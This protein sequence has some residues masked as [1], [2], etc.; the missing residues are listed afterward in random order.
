MS[1]NLERFGK[2]PIP[3]IGT[4]GVRRSPFEDVRERT[5]GTL[6]GVWAKLS[7]LAG[8]RG[9]DGRYH[10]WGLSRTHGDEPSQKALALAHSEVYLQ[11]LRTPIRALDQEWCSQERSGEFMYVENLQSFYPADTS[12]GSARHLSSL[13]L[14]ARLLSADRQA[15]TRLS[16]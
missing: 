11:V 15:S 6:T 5:L 3:E 4:G 8:L 10:H 13:L 2:L 1:T 7:Y 9:D 16:A 14:A 12:G